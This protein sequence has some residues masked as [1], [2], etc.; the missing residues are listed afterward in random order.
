MFD[1]KKEYHQIFNKWRDF[2]F[3]TSIL[4]ISGLLLAISNYEIG[5]SA[6]YI[7][8]SLDIDAMDDPRNTHGS[9][10]IVRLIIMITTLMAVGC[11]IMRHHYKILW[12]N[13]Y[14]H[15]YS[16]DHIYY[17]YNEVITGKNN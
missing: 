5:V 4:A 15:Q 14:F 16:E 7:P 11:L 1:Q 9:T 17:Q 10:N 13:K 12:L 8:P 3:I 6:D 2:D